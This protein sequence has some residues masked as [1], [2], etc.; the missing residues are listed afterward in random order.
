MYQPQCSEQWKIYIPDAL[1]QRIVHWYRMLLCHPGIQQLYATV[2]THFY[3]P[4]MMEFIETYI[5]N[6]QHLPT[7]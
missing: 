1:Q 6:L 5:T 3:F 4:C 7:Q 2:S